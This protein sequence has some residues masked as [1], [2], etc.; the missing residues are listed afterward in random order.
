[1]RSSAHCLSLTVYCSA[2]RFVF[3]ASI[4]VKLSCLKVKPTRTPY[5]YPQ[6]HRI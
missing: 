6:C 3:Q 4:L 2:L 1:M 5:S